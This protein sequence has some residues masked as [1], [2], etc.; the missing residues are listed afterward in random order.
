MIEEED[1]PR[2]RTHVVQKLWLKGQFP[3]KWTPPAS[4][5]RGGTTTLAHIPDPELPRSKV[6]P[7]IGAALGFYGPIF[8]NRWN[9]QPIYYNAG[10][11]VA[12]AIIGGLALPWMYHRLNVMAAKIYLVS[13]GAQ[14]GDHKVTLDYGI[15]AQPSYSSTSVHPFPPKLTERNPHY[16]SLR[17]P[18]DDRAFK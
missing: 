15:K 13:E 12:G 8:R 2:Q 6:T 9:G 3:K 16:I 5:Q 10:W 14:I 11:A 7:W 4:L 1:R 18:E 17:V